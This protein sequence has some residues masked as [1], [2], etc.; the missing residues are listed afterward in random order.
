LPA[1]ATRAVPL[2]DLPRQADLR[3][4]E[5]SVREA[6]RLLSVALRAFPT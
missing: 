6:D 3:I 1:L 5:R 4:P 2:T